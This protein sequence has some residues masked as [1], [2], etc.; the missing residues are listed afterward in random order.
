[1]ARH[2]VLRARIHGLLRHTGGAAAVEFAVILPLMMIMFFGTFEVTQLVKAYMATNRAAQ[3]LANLVAQ[4]GVMGFSSA[5]STDYCIA[6]KDVMA[7]MAGSGLA[8]TIASVTKNISTGAVAFD[9]QDTTCGG[10]AGS[11]ISASAASN[12]L[13]ANNG[14]SVI[15]VKVSYNYQA[16]VHFVLPSSF[17]I[18]QT[19]YQRQRTGAS[20]P[21]S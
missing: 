2:A 19:S 21:Q 12:G 3:I 10:G 1:M 6:A 8:A 13:V 7:P 4:E 5:H 11:F 17:T 20:T 15:I 14:D 9:W 18:T 16:V